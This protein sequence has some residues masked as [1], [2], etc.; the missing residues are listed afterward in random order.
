M[1]SA[2]IMVEQVAAQKRIADESLAAVI[3]RTGGV[4][5][6]IEELTRAVLDGGDN[7]LIKSAIPVSLKDSLMARLDRLG[8]A[9]EVAQ[10]GAVIGNEFS[11]ELIRAVHPISERNLQAALRELTEAELLYFHGSVPRGTY[12]F[13]H[14]LIRDAAYEALLKKRR[15]DLHRQV[16]RRIEDNF[17]TVARQHPELLAHH[18]TEAGEAQPAL[19]NWQSA[20]ERALERRAFCEAEQ[21]YCHALAMLE[22]T[23]PQSPERDTRE[24]SLQVA[25]GAVMMVTRG[26]SAHDTAEVYRRARVVAERASGA[27]SVQVLFGLS[28]AALARSE[29]GPALSL[30][31]ELLE[32][33]AG[34]HSPQALATAHYAQAL[35]RH[36]LGDLVRAR[37]HFIQAIAHHRQADFV[38]LPLAD[39]I[40]GALIIGG[41]NKWQLGYPERARN[42]AEEALALANAEL[43]PTL[44]AFALATSCY[45]HQLRRDYDRTLEASDEGTKLAAAAELPLLNALCVFYNTWA[46]A[47]RGEIEGAA[48]QMRTALKQFDAV[49]FSLA[50][51]GL[52]GLLCETQVLLGS[53]DDA[54]VTIHQALQANP[55]ELIFRPDLLRLRGELRI[56]HHLENAAGLAEADFRAAIQLAQRIRAKSAEL[57]ASTSLARL[58]AMQGRR[59]EARA[60]LTDVYQWFTEGFE[61]PDLKEAEVLLQVLCG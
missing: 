33:G 58:L 13:K 28:S 34:Q 9:K 14:A 25:L 12:F 41:A 23:I 22:R 56:R 57:R 7:G 51:G 44:R 52:L 59:S 53:L 1:R 54:C 40:F 47:H 15:K 45:V 8:P 11:Y 16:A 18:W 24:L 31:S 26:W 43:N 2:R 32:I 19:A 6:F 36:Y 21:H 46:R 39:P 17:P 49:N 38:H 60:I 35:P 20:A 5:S 42:Y 50:R 29:H 10:V 4:P 27:N 30:A 37:E 3:E 61:T 48:E 55:D